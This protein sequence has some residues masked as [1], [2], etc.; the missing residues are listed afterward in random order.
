MNPPSVFPLS[1]TVGAV[2]GLSLGLG[3]QTTAVVPAICEHLP[4]NAAVAM[5]LRWSEGVMQVRIEEDLLPANLGASI[6]G[7]RLRR[8][9]FLAE[10]AY[11]AVQRTLTVRGGFQ[12]GSNQSA[13]ALTRYRDFNRQP[14][15]TVLFGPAVVAVGAT[16]APGPATAVGDEFIAITFTTPLPVAPGSLM[17][18]F[19]TTDAPFQVIGDSWVDAVWFEGGVESGY[20]VTLGDGSCTTRSGPTELRWNDPAT[21]PVVGGTASFRMTGAQPNVLTAILIGLTPRPRAANA[22]YVGFGASLTALDP[23]LGGCHQWAPVDGMASGVA[24]VAGTTDF[25]FPL[26]TD[27][28]TVGIEVGVQSL[29]LDTSRPGFPISVSNGVML[30][31]DEID[32]GDQCAT[33]FFPG[34]ATFSPWE[35]YLGQMPVIVLEHN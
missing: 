29:W 9:T 17:L 14:G 6:T 16:A 25:S 3:A 31:L 12:T 19:E 23:G 21:G 27:P 1:T 4:G 26:F 2:L 13:A 8:P 5:P 32:V 24:N 15:A 30:V 22:N 18:E 11:P 35:P 7:V 10:P 34:T 33:V 20:A 28:S